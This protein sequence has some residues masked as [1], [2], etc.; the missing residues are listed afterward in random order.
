MDTENSLKVGRLDPSANTTLQNDTVYWIDEE[1]NTKTRTTSRFLSNGSE[2]TA[3]KSGDTL[4]FGSFSTTI[5]GTM[6]QDSS[7]SSIFSQLQLKDNPRLS[8]NEEA[9]CSLGTLFVS[10]NPNNNANQDESNRSSINL[11]PNFDNYAHT[12]SNVSSLSTI[13]PTPKIILQES[14]AKPM[15]KNYLNNNIPTHP[16]PGFSSIS[17]NQV[18]TST[19]Q[20]PIFFKPVD[21]DKLSHHEVPEDLLESPGGKPLVNES[22]KMK[23]AVSE[24]NIN[25]SLMSKPSRKMDQMANV[26]Q[27]ELVKNEVLTN[28]EP[29]KVDKCKLSNANCPSTSGSNINPDLR[30]QTDTEVSESWDHKP[31]RKSKTK[32]QKPTLDQ[33]NTHNSTN[34]NRNSDVSP[35]SLQHT[36]SSTVLIQKSLHSHH[37]SSS[38]GP[39]RK[40]HHSS[41]E[42]RQKQRL[43]RTKS[44]NFLMNKDLPELPPETNAKINSKR[45]N[46][47]SGT[48][49]N[50]SKPS[51]LRSVP[52]RCNAALKS[53]NNSKYASI[54]D[55][56]SITNNLDMINLSINKWDDVIEKK[57]SQSGNTHEDMKISKVRQPKPSP[58][59]SICDIPS[60]YFQ[61]LPSPA[62]VST[63]K[64]NEST[65]QSKP[66][67]I[68]SPRAVDMT[69]ME[70]SK[71]DSR[72]EKYG[73]HGSVKGYDLSRTHQ[74][75]NS[76][77]HHHNSSSVMDVK[78]ND[79]ASATGPPVPPKDKH[80]GSFPSSLEKQNKCVSYPKQANSS[81]NPTFNK[82]FSFSN[83]Q[84]PVKSPAQIQVPSNI[85]NDSQSTNLALGTRSMSLPMMQH[86]D[87]LSRRQY[88]EAGRIRHCGEY[89]EEETLLPA[90]P[91]CEPNDHSMTSP[92]QNSV[93]IHISKIKSAENSS[94]NTSKVLKHVLDDTINRDS[95]TTTFSEAITM[96]APLPVD[97]NYY[98][99]EAT[100][101]RRK[102]SQSH[103]IS[104]KLAN[105]L[106]NIHAV[107]HKL[108]TTRDAG[109]VLG[110]TNVKHHN[111]SFSF[112]GVS[113]WSQYKDQLSPKGHQMSS[114]Q[115]I[116]EI[117]D[118]SN[119]ILRP[120]QHS[121]VNS[122]SISNQSSFS[123]LQLNDLSPNFNQDFIGTNNTSSSSNDFTLNLV[124]TNQ[125][126]PSPPFDP[127]LL[128]V[129]NLD[130]NDSRN[131]SSPPQRKWKWRKQ[132]SSGVKR[133]S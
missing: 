110:A 39:S 96:P 125:T 97:R 115:Y 73:K 101:E 12:N 22:F 3:Q 102:H 89:I 18:P 31:H 106:H 113:Q 32:T 29:P 77:H 28:I 79:F 90:L 24:S 49:A 94:S 23:P 130:N 56:E 19:F 7:F 87:A 124:S 9:L 104:N 75:S 107:R 15:P 26:N 68:Q 98:T 50:A 8:I 81:L 82:N 61:P 57:D 119:L 38:S 83:S 2:S 10:E 64:S 47:R 34:R 60:Y 27:H 59:Y 91:V 35:T 132:S 37:S 127:L 128:P 30:L 74:K 5:T 62:P 122:K 126:P 17:S 21:F 25:K 114:N 53:T 20:T 103:S 116:S 55:W 4:S 95:F 33:K 99:S 46:T 78:Q 41:S 123:G 11:A 92:K 45:S 48:V 93:N 88:K 72:A 1:E 112:N 121:L 80:F 133:N 13:T 66:I 76:R 86:Q 85:Y 117:H 100:S 70:R 71:P 54:L 16:S 105:G 69:F 120:R 58:S 65:V 6:D 131:D 51:T 108:S 109:N 52:G 40:K 111:Q 118:P 43:D 63:P 42:S 14:V 129:T 84:L 36:T 67:S 44:K